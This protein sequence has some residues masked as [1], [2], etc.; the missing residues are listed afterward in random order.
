GD[1]GYYTALQI[2]FKT[3]EDAAYNTP[4]GQYSQPIR[5]SL[6]YHIIKVNDV[7]PAR[8]KIKVAMIKRLIPEDSNLVSAAKLKV[9]SIYNVLIS[10][11]DFAQVAME[12]SEDYASG[13]RGGEL[14]WFTINTFN[15]VFEEAAFGLKNIGDISKPAR[16][17]KSWYII[18]L[19]NRTDAGKFEDIAPSLTAR[20]ANHPQYEEVMRHLVDSLKQKY[21]YSFNKD[22]YLKMLT[23]LSPAL[24]TFAGIFQTAEPYQTVLKIG[25]RNI[26]DFTLGNAMLRSS[27]QIR[28]MDDHARWHEL[29]F[30]KALRELV[31]EYHRDQLL[32]NDRDL[33][34]LMKE[35]RDGILLFD[36]TEK[37]V[38]NKA[39]LDTAGLKSYYAEHKD[40]FRQ[41][42]RLTVYTYKAA[43]E[44]DAKKLKGLLAKNN[45]ADQK[46][47]TE[48]GLASIAIDSITVEKGKPLPGGIS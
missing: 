25:D 46:A 28:R 40:E 47:L 33:S 34:Y 44:K 19:L 1:L 32:K 36:L 15:P 45:M 16:T 48:Q 17:A 13:Q 23:N 41:P 21:G 22:E 18:K 35:Y 38:W 37:E 39:I 5:T 27:V 6:G 3:L 26:D 2:N 11:A 43:N 24:D 29:L 42:E 4:E 10:G 8:G 31:M 12:A 20:L 14:D 9:D 7:R 30:N